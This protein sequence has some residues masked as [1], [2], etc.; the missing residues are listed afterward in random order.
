MNINYGLCLI[1]LGYSPDL[2]TDE[3]SA[4]SIINTWC[5]ETLQCPFNNGEELVDFC[6]SVIEVVNEKIKSEIREQLYEETVDKETLHYY[7]HLA[8]NEEEEAEEAKQLMDEAIIEVE[9]ILN[10]L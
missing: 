5:N 10:N 3:S 7:R 9:N 2:W 8:N 6:S 1:E 4:Q